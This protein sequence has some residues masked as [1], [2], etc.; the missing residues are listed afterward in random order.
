M[1]A[2]TSRLWARHTR[3]A[4]CRS[5]K[6]RRISITHCPTTKLS[7]TASAASAGAPCY[8][9]VVRTRFGERVIVFRPLP[10]CCRLN[11]SPVVLMWELHT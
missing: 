4:R 8:V 1:P 11:A 9:A 3:S 10:I 2:C 7:R 6:A 5:T